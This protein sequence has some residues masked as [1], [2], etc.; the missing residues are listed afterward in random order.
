VIRSFADKDT[1]QL[2]Q[3]ESPRRIPSTIHR[4]A[5]RKLLMIDAAVSLTDLTVPPENRLEKLIGN[6]AEQYSIRINEQ[7]RICFTWHEN[8]AYNVEIVDYH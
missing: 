3:L 1:A 6:R 8:D 4:T 7:Y 2:F 5:L